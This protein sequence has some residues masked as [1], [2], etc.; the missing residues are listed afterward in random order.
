[1]LEDNDLVIACKVVE[2][3]DNGIQQEKQ[4]LL[5]TI[6]ITMFLEKLDQLVF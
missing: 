3:R 4:L 6:V 5:L 2:C 1:M